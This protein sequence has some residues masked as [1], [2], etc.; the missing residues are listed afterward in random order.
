MYHDLDA[1]VH[2]KNLW[3]NEENAI[4]SIIELTKNMC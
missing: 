2:D 1:I 4:E 3:L